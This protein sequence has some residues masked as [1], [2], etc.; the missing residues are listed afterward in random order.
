MNGDDQ[1]ECCIL[2][3]CCGGPNKTKAKAALAALLHEAGIPKPHADTAAAV[4]LDTFD[5][6]P[7]GTLKPYR[8]AVAALAREYPYTQDGTDA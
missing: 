5:L 3:V 1:Q 6:A 8:D 2:G 4:V 7:V